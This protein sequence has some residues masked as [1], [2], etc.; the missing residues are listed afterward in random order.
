MSTPRP[1]RVSAAPL[2]TRRSRRRRFH[3][4]SRKRR[5]RLTITTA[6]SVVTLVVLGVSVSGMIGRA[7]AMEG[8]A[9]TAA[10]IVQLRDGVPIDE[11]TDAV[12]TAQ[13]ALAV[14]SGLP[15]GKASTALADAATAAED[16]LATA[17]TAVQGSAGIDV[18][19]ADALA[20]A[21]GVQGR[22]DALRAA[23]DASTAQLDA[24]TAARTAFVDSAVAGAD[25]VLGDYS[26]AEKST[27]DAL[28]VA[29]ET[30]STAV[31][32][33]AALQTATSAAADVRSSAG[34]YRAEIAAQ[35]TGSQPTG[36]D[37][38]AQLEYL[39]AYATDYN[40]ADWGDD[41]PSGGDCV[42]FT[43]QGLLARGWQ[44]DGTWSSTG[45]SGGSKA[46]VL[47]PAMDEYLQ[48]NGFVSHGVD[49]LDR[50]RVGDV[51]IFDW[52]ENG[53]GRD[54]TM[55]VSKVDYTV[56]GP[57]I[58]FASHNS[59]GPYRELISALYEEHS[60]STVKI[61]SIP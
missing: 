53:A 26:D 54:H 22:V 5:K 42:N 57:I 31:D 36:G 46:W 50:V 40:T 52:G 12:A 41:N 45:P 13:A 25:D 60:D 14:Q 19:H 10:E 29:R 30:L 1:T 2:E 51:G 61:Y 7:Q 15:S 35:V 59:D 3:E 58:S 44:M 55:T 27:E 6:V 32:V 21:S 34:G 43:S 4:L 24:L 47:T 23:A 9:A 49:D 8:Y 18:A 56:E 16:A 28:Y 33:A 17:Q 37:V 11:L 48:A 38:A 39:L 20:T